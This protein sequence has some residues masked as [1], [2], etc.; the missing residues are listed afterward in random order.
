M[1]KKSRRNR[2]K[3]SKQSNPYDRVAK[4]FEERKYKEVLEKESEWLLMA[5]ELES[6]SR[7]AGHIGEEKS[8]STV[9]NIYDILAKSHYDIDIRI[10]IL[11]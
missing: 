11:R 2:T 8:L 6:L 4:L 10:L 1:G 7:A 3:P 9:L 5:T